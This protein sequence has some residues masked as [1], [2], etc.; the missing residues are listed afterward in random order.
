MKC[1]HVQQKLVDYSESLVDQK[2]RLLIEEHLQ[3]CSECSQELK[4]FEE[5]IHLIQSVSIQEPSDAFWDDFTAGIM[6]KIEMTGKT[7]SVETKLFFSPSFRMAA[8]TVALL[9]LLVGGMFAYST[10]AIR[11]V[12]PAFFSS[13][14]HLLVESAEQPAQVS[15][16]VEEDGIVSEEFVDD[17]PEA[18]LALLGR[19][20]W[21][22]FTVGTYDET[23]YFLIENLSEEEKDLFLKE[24][25]QMR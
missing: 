25:E 16:G 11:K 19:A 24:L 8:V 5:T 23:L 20:A 3:N 7:S 18:D 15:S 17:I 9:L 13:S 4:D 2:T 10:G 22:N 1:K 21:E 14:P 6:R 12:L